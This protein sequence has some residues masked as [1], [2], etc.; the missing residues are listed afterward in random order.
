MNKKI[1]VIIGCVF[2]SLCG[3]EELGNVKQIINKNTELIKELSK[4][5]NEMNE[6]YNK[7]EC[8]IYEDF[9]RIDKQVQEY[10]KSTNRRLGILENGSQKNYRDINLLFKK[11]KQTNPIIEELQRQVAELEKNLGWVY[12]EL[13]REIN[14]AGSKREELENKIEV[15]MNQLT[16]K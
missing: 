2:I 4:K 1:C 5:I 10:K 7:F 11:H 13:Q 16:K 9:S 8:W 12:A 6:S 15:L 3:S 14:S